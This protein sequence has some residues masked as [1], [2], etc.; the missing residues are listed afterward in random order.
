[1]DVNWVDFDDLILAYAVAVFSLLASSLGDRDWFPLADFLL[2]ADAGVNVHFPSLIN[3]VPTWMFHRAVIRAHDQAFYAQLAQSGAEVDAA[4]DGH[5]DGADEYDDE[6]ADED[7]GN[8]ADEQEEE[9]DEEE[10]MASDSEA[11]PRRRD[12]ADKYGAK[13]IDE[14]HGDEVEEEEEELDEEEQMASDPEML[15]M[16]LSTVIEVPEALR[17]S[18]VRPSEHR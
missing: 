5:R 6:G 10:N 18:A 1:M 9:P 16:R 14:D 4:D 13:G 8:E 15:Y 2:A 17:C 12:G 11:A 7:H 3:G